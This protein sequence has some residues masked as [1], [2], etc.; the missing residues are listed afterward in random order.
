MEAFKEYLQQF[1]HYH[2]SSFQKALPFL[3][4]LELL[5]GQHFLEYGKICKKIAFIQ[6]GLLR[7]Y[8]LNDGREITSCFCKENTITT[9]YKSLTTQTSS[10]I[11]I[12]AIESSE[13]VLLPYDALL[14]LYKED[15]FW[16]QVGRLVIEREYFITEDHHRFVNDLDATER[17]LQILNTSPDL[18]QRV[19]LNYLASYLQIVPE[20]L[21]RI[22][23]RIARN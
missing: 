13:L 21:S 2:P 20:T 4:K 3:S 15:L 10:D 9:A 11:G 14:K 22:R 5:E 7:L 1:P 8:Y 12:Q 23:R 6:K 18:L 17:Y 19:P 16:Q